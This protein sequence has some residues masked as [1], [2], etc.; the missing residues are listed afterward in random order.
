MQAV[1]QGPGGKG[2]P[3]Q[4]KPPTDPALCNCDDCA[5]ALSP[6]AYLVDLLDFTVKRI[7]DGNTLITLQS[8]M[9][10]LQQ[11]FSDLIASCDMDTP[12]RQVRICIEVLRIILGQTVV[13]DSVYRQA[14]YLALLDQAGVAYRGTSAVAYQWCRSTE[15]ACR[16]PG[17]RSGW[18]PT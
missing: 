12:V 13:D 7:M 3:Q 2:Q 6:R 4:P 9:A 10:M 17:N 14:A 16:S 1:W 18:E 11:P 8:L 15:G 5:A